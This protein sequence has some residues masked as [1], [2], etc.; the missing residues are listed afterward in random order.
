MRAVCRYFFAYVLLRGK[1]KYA[2]L[3]YTVFTTYLYFNTV[4]I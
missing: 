3:L 1:G 2:T 4:I